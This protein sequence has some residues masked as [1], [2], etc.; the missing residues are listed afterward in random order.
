MT[1]PATPLRAV[2]FDLDGLMFNTEE[3]YFEVGTRLLARRDKQLTDDLLRQMMGRPSRVSL[4]IMIDW[5]RLAA[6][7]EQLERETDEIFDELLPTRLQPMP[8]LI[9]LLATIEE[10]GIPKA[11][12]TS[13]RRPFVSKVLSFF[14]L[15]PR[16]HCI[17][18]CEDVS[19]GK[20]HPEVYLQAA[21]RLGADPREVMVLEDSHHG[22]R[23]AIAA[24]TFAVAVPGAHSA[25]HDFEGAAFI[26]DS[27]LDARIYQALGVRPGPAQQ[28]AYPTN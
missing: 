26:A 22:C 1:D 24:G 11:I 27:L 25:H 23:A 8:G 3:L 15:E 4:Q 20:P 13:S 16:F 6:T 5:H 18:T 21:G 12:G 2:V 7:V 9:P 17:L 19:Q 28:D 14:Q 10:I